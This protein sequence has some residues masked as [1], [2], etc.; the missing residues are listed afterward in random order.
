M[1]GTI[2]EANC[3]NSAYDSQMADAFLDNG[4]A[5]YLGYTHVV[6]AGFAAGKATDTW[7][8]LLQNDNNTVGDIPGLFTAHDTNNPPAYFTA[9]GDTTAT[10][11]KANLLKDNEVYVQYNWPQD[12]NDLDS[13]TGFLGEEVGYNLPGGQYLD[14]SGDNTGAGGSETTTVD[15]YQAWL[16]GAWSKTT[17]VS[18]GADWYTPAGGSGPA[19]VTV[20]LENINTGKLTHVTNQVVNPGQETEGAHDVVG[21]VT[22]VLG[23]NAS[24]PTVAIEPTWT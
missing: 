3:C 18:V 2:V 13:N 11:P 21:T 20:A 14:W 1:N 7:T 19:Y 15:I 9:Y 22:V 23:G 16:D 12:V 10:L 17:T 24:N 6:K 5:A 8:T 4:A